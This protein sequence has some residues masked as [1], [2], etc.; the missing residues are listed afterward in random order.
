MVDWN[1]ANHP[2][3]D[4]YSPYGS[5][6]SRMLPLH[7]TIVQHTDQ[8]LNKELLLFKGRHSPNHPPVY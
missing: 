4:A 1:R 6:T 5:R 2:G 8:S 7:H 3:M